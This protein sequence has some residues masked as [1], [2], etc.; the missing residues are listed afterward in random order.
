M[1]E[2]TDIIKQTMNIGAVVGLALSIYAI[3]VHLLGHSYSPNSD[4]GNYLIIIGGITGGSAYLRNNFFPENFSYSQALL[5]G[6]LISLFAAIIYAFYRY[7]FYV[8]IDKQAIQKMFD[9]ME[10]AMRK[11]NMSQADIDTIVSKP[12]EQATPLNMSLYIIPTLSIIGFIISL[13][14]AIFIKRKTIENN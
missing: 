8:Y 12:R 3:I 9:V 1:P 4:Y 14:S 2:K 7:I 13:F 6:S 11:E 10:Q 5:T